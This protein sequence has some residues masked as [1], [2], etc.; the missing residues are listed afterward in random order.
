MSD[1]IPKDQKT[2]PI[3]ENNT[4]IPFYKLYNPDLFSIDRLKNLQPVN[5]TVNDI[6]P[7]I[8]PII[9]F[10][11][12]FLTMILQRHHMKRYLMLKGK[13][14]ATMSFIVNYSCF[15]YLLFN[16]DNFNKSI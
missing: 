7:R 15:Y 9:S 3:L 10:S 5:L 12:F 16:I 8:H 2:H 14:L 11:S 1:D 4:N 6:D 13:T